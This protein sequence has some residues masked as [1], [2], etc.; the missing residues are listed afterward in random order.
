MTL[1]DLIDE[2]SEFDFYQAVYKIESQLSVEDKAWLSVGRDS[3]PGKELVRFK[4]DQHLGFPG[5]PI[6]KV[7]VQSNDDDLTSIDMHVSFMG[8]TGPSGVLPRHYSEL[9]LKCI[10]NRDTAMRDFFDL[11]N[12][13][14]ISLHYRAWQKYRMASHYELGGS[15]LSDPYSKALASLSGAQES[16]QIY[17]GGLFNKSN[18]SAEGLRCILKDFLDCNVD[19]SELEGKWVNLSEIDQTKLAS[20]LQPEG[21]YSRLGTEAAL[22]KKVWDV[23]SGIKVTVSPKNHAQV[24]NLLP[25]K[26]L[27][28]KLQQLIKDYVDDGLHVKLEVQAK[29]NDLP[30]ANLGNES[31]RLGQ[32]A[33]L[34]IRAQ[35]KNNFM[36]I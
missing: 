29:F 27:H 17:Y 21:Q 24:T 6:S 33:R 4:S 3:F 14:L 2:P 26:A 16:L 23:S 7:D 9:I 25:G 20:R 22:G 18:R 35:N 31:A 34:S 15:D 28:Q 11:F 1:R 5:R 19:V 36:S 10:K 32:S 30:N 8:L 13:R 12:H